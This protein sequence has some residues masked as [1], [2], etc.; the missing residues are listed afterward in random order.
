MRRKEKN[1][2]GGGEKNT[3][4]IERGKIPHQKVIAMHEKGNNLS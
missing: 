2:Q 3:A 4:S 1:L